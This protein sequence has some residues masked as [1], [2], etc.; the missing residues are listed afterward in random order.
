[1][2]FDISL[3]HVLKMLLHSSAFA[4]CLPS[5]IQEL[6]FIIFRDCGV[7]SALIQYEL[8]TFKH[9][10]CLLDIYKELLLWALY[11]STWQPS[12]RVFGRRRVLPFLTITKSPVQPTFTCK[13]LPELET[14]CHLVLLILIVIIFLII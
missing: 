12:L 5:S 14:A 6:V 11:S 10:E 13:V 8:F 3:L 7:C 1:M 4:F 2:Y 9:S